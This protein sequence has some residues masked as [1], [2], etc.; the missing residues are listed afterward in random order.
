MTAAAISPVRHVSRNGVR[1]VNLQRDLAQ[2]A[3][4]IELCFGPVLDRS[5]WSAVREM[6]ALGQFRPLVWMLTGLTGTLPSWGLGFVWEE[7]GR[8]VGNVSVQRSAADPR[9]WLI[10]NVAVHPSFRRRGIARALTRA[11]IALARSQEGRSAILQVDDDNLAAVDLYRSLAFVPM[12]TRTVWHRSPGPVPRYP[13]TEFDV[14]PRRGGD[15]KDQYSLARQAMPEGLAW[16]QPLRPSDFRPSLSQSFSVFFNGQSREDWVV[17]ESG[18]R[19]IGSVTTL[20]NDG[21]YDTLS[22]LVHPDRQGQI[23]QALLVRALRRLGRRPWPAGLEY[24][25]GVQ[26]SEAVFEGLDFQPGRK[27]LWMKVIL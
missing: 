4:L 20:T 3:D 12:T 10:A 15:W 24:P 9:E 18:G 27:L 8:V 6:K 21:G 16:N 11:A 5:G 13:R 14:R 1:P 7:D 17:R 26:S 2:I 22:V 25:S 23:E 19:L